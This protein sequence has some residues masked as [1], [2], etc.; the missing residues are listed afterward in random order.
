MIIDTAS[1]DA[2]SS[3]KLL[4]GS[5]LPRAIAWVSTRSTAGVGNVAPVSFFTVV[6]RLPPTVS[7]SLQPRSDEVTLK[8]TFVNIRDTGEFVVNMVS[9]GQVDEAHR[10][11]FEFESEVDEFEALGLEKAECEV[12]S[13]PR[14]AGAPISMEC[15]VDRIIPMPPL[16]DHVVWGRVERFHVRDDLYLPGGRID[17]GALGA[18]GRLAAEYS[19]VN[20]IFTTPLPEELVE[21]LLATRSARLD[22]RP[23]DF[24]PID[25]AEWSPSGSTKTGPK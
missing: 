1:L 17:T 4:I 16:P 12:V 14:I 2:R 25:T 3:Y 10:S 18:V 21:G 24:S 7:I 5:V 23:T 22:E 20:N 6:G 11:A 19:L 8:D 9:L 15:V 13:A